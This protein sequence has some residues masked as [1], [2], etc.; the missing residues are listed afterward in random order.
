M[1]PG[2]RNSGAS[3]GPEEIHPFTLRIYVG[4]NPRFPYLLLRALA[5][6]AP[7]FEGGGWGAGSE[8]RQRN[9]G[10][11]LEVIEPAHHAEVLARETIR[12]AF[13]DHNHTL[14]WYDVGSYTH[15]REYVLLCNLRPL[16]LCCLFV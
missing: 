13:W 14:L 7:I 8:V 16:S 3:L 2:S 1:H 12:I 15:Y 6:F 9:A 11:A 4:R 5:A 10:D